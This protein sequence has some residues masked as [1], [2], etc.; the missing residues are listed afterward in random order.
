MDQSRQ[1]SNLAS[2]RAQG[3]ATLPMDDWDRGPWNRWTFQHIGE[4][5]PTQRVW[6]GP[7]PVSP[8]PDDTQ[9]ILSLP[10]AHDGTEEK[11]G[12]YFSSMETDGLL[13][14]HR[15]K[16]IVER[17]DNDMERNTLHLSQSVGKSVAG[18]VAGVLVG[19]GVIDP[20][21]PITHY[22]PELE[23]TA[24]KGATL[25]HVLDMTSG[26]VFNE[27]YTAP[28]SHMAQ[29]DVACGWKT[30][31]APD[32]PKTMWDLILSLKEQERPHGAEFHYRSI[33]TDVLSFAMQ[34]A[35]G[36]SIADLISQHIW[37]PMGAEEDASLTL[38]PAG[39]GL[40]CGGFNASLRDY[41]RF[42]HIYA[43]GGRAN[44]RQVVP[45]AWI[46]DTQKADASRFT[47]GY[48]HV[49]PHGAYRNQFWVER[50]GGPVMLARG[51]FGQML[52]IDPEADF[53]GVVLSSWAD[54]VNPERTRKTLSAMRAIRAVL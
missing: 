35:T 30:Y 8:L 18:A 22:L 29:M 28:D 3:R 44:G 43:S 48:R 49:L 52:F 27:D 39:Y 54:F 26:V 45:P 34:A 10:F 2:A 20:D 13:V 38:D 4:I 31:G 33:E 40:A 51:V 11:L 25:R 17:Y 32:W 47:E 46:A 6:R 37:Q 5:L 1:I 53:V 16:V 41:A 12:D 15:G 24:Y 42:A 14:L 9:D 7:G 23:A 21:A 36:L 19:Q 50:A